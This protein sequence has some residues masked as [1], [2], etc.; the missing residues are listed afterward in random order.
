MNV[1]NEV[2]RLRRECS[3]LGITGVD[4]CKA[5]GVKAQL[6]SSW[7]T[8]SKG[9][10]KYQ[11]RASV[12]K[13]MNEKLAA[14]RKTKTEQAGLKQPYIK[15]PPQFDDETPIVLPN[16]KPSACEILTGII[17]EKLR[18]MTLVQLAQVI[19]FIEGNGK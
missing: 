8:R 13:R 17:Q 12:L 4:L 16:H 9:D 18:G 1:A 14:L 19:G 2:A 6:I 3:E 5:V 7:I 15:P 10:A 11:P